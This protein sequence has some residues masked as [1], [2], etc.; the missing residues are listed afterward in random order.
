MR[1]IIPKNACLVPDHAERVFK[2]VIYNVY[3]WRQQMFDGSQA[4]FEMLKRPDT[5]KT[6]A[7]KDDT[8]I[9]LDERQPHGNRYYE[10]PGGRHDVAS[11]DELACAKRELLEETGMKFKN[12][13]L[14][15]A[16]Q[17]ALKIEAFVYIYLATEFESQ[18]TP[19]TDAGEQISLHPVN[20]DEFLRLAR[21][22]LHGTYL[23]LNVL[24]E[25]GSLEGL[26]KLPTYSN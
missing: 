15:L 11:E 4:T 14:L 18:T 5:V 23:P 8:I 7:V 1:T 17:P 24:D 22:P 12:W 25:A 9:M 2:G 21:D 20:F 13:R 10:L 26:L 6:I 19:K 16:Y 3:Q